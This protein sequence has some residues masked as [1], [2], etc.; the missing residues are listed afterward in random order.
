MTRRD[1]ML[2][3]LAALS[4][5]V[6]MAASAVTL[7]PSGIDPRLRL[8]WEAHEDRRG[9]PVISGYIYNDSGQ[10][11]INLRLV[12]E[13]VDTSGH[14]VDRAVGFVTAGV[15]AFNRSYFSVALHQS[16]A[17]YRIAVTGFDWKNNGF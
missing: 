4:A 7:S 15:P 2:L 5:A 3:L 8:E 6:P 10:P 11:A 12:A 9:R 1:A 13:G 16:A 17:G 14:V